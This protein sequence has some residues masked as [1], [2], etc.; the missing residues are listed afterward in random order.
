MSL[1]SSTTASYHP[2]PSRSQSITDPATAAV[3]QIQTTPVQLPSRTTATFTAAADPVRFPATAGPL[4]RSIQYTTMSCPS[5]THLTVA[6][7]AGTKVQP[8]GNAERGY[9]ETS[10]VAMH[11]DIAPTDCHHP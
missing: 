11:C 9:P 4:R 5:S 3:S 1:Q 7:S 8:S 6:M 2:V 10:V